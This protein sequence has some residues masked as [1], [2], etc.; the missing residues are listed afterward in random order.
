MVQYERLEKQKVELDKRFET[1]IS[2]EFRNQAE[3]VLSTLQRNEAKKVFFSK[4]RVTEKVEKLEVEL[5]EM[6]KKFCTKCQSLR[7]DP[8]LPF[9]FCDYCLDNAECN[10]H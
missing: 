9:K 8:K 2:D 6:Q 1:L 4:K 3:G 10:K 7:T 5:E